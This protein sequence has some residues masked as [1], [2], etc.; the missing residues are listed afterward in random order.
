MDVGLIA[1]VA[2]AV[3]L[4]GIVPLAEVRYMSGVSL[5]TV[6]A[7][8]LGLALVASPFLYLAARRTLHA[9]LPTLLTHNKHVVVYG[10]VGLALSLGATAAYLQVLKTS[11]KN[12]AAVVAATC[13]YPA[14]TALIMW[15]LYGHRI[16]WTGWLGIAFVIGGLI[17]LTL[18]SA[19]PAA[20]PPGA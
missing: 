4:W 5:V 12:T 8:F 19:A 9:E 14:V 7:L 10:S 1:L 11:G 15:F 17:L 16:T 18:G 13:I 3:V 2:L 20:G 6:A